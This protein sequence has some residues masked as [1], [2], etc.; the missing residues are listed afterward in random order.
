MRIRL[1]KYMTPLLQ[2]L[3]RKYLSRDRVF[4]YKSIRIIVH[5]GVFYPGFIFSTKIL[6]AYLDK[7]D[8]SGKRL[9]D[10]G[11]GSGIISLLAALNGAKVTATDINPEAVRNLTE[12]ARL[13]NLE[14][15]VLESDLF[16]N[17]PPACYDYIVINPPYYPEDPSNFAEMAMFCGKNFEY[18]ENF[19]QQLH[20]YYHDTSTILVTLSEDCNI[21]FIMNLASR[22]GFELIMSEKKIKMGEWNY[23]FRIKKIISHAQQH[24][25]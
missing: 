23:I 11:A 20:P 19:F 15:T 6:L 2:P 5:P 24:C 3:Y 7:L 21:P 9:L 13:N 12:N 1:I 17:I 14:V 22:H 4:R 10:L 25:V 8:L 18:F 16:K